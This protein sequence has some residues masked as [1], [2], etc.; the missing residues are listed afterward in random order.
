MNHDRA[1]EMLDHTWNYAR[2]NDNQH[3]TYPIGYCSNHTLLNEKYLA[4]HKHATKEEAEECYKKYELDN[5]LRLNAGTI[6]EETL[7]KCHECKEF[8]N[9]TTTV[10]GWRMYYLCDEHR[11]RETMEKIFVVG[12]SFHS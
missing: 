6:G 9:I 5:N 1:L 4:Y 8:T 2:T 10:N 7:V 3:R 12:E 11:T